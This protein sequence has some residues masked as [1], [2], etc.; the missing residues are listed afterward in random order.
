MITSIIST[1]QM[2]FSSIPIAN[3][4]EMEEERAEKLIKFYQ[5]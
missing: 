3:E 2:L 1:L 4:N 5:F